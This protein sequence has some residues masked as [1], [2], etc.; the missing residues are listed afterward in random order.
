M[1]EPKIIRLKDIARAGD[2]PLVTLDRKS[3][4]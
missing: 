3:V 2:E 4:V 1:N